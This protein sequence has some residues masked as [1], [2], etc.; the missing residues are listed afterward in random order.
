M[1]W[2]DGWIDGWK[3]DDSRRSPLV[4]IF[5]EEFQS[6]GEGGIL[7]SPSV[8][9]TNYPYGDGFWSITIPPLSFPRERELLRLPFAG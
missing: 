8:P 2:L 1:G 6:R 5:L 7:S 9:P 4:W 3:G